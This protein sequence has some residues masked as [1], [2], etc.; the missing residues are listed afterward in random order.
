MGQRP[1]SGAKRSALEDKCSFG[2]HDLFQPLFQ[3]GLKTF[4]DVSRRNSGQ[5]ADLLMSMPD[6]VEPLLVDKDIAWC[7]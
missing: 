4:R 3:Y 1:G 7:R 5:G 2:Y 6:L